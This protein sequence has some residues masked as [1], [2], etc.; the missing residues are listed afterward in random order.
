MERDWTRINH[1]LRTPLNQ[2]IGFT[3]LLLEEC[4]GSAPEEWVS[5]LR[6]IERAAYELL[7]LL[8]EMFQAC[9]VVPRTPG[10]EGEKP[11]PKA[12]G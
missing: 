12:R 8:D 6:Q 9:R 5:D 11:D 2:I 1:E 3:Q 7:H 4:E 10:Q